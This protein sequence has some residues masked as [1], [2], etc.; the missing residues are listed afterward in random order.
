MRSYDGRI[1]KLD[2]H[3]YRLKESAKACGA[4]LSEAEILSFRKTIEKAIKKSR[5]KNAYIRLAVSL[6]LKERSLIIKELKRYPDEIF[7]KGA[8]LAT[9]CV[10][11]TSAA[12]LAVNIKSS[13]F[14]SA[15]LAKSESPAV[16]DALML[17]QDSYAA[18]GTVSNI[19]IVK[20]KI[21]FTPPASSGLLKGITRGVILDLAKENS[22]AASEVNLT[23][24][25]L[26]N[27]DECFLTNTTIE[28]LP[29]VEI[30]GR[31]IGSG[32]PGK[33]T[34]RLTKMFHIGCGTIGCHETHKIA[35]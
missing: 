2:E 17:Q 34:K 30:D 3:L 21:L 1:F 6:P 25:D 15:V 22:I 35:G 12:N 11:K 14:L 19:F 7:Q 4:E 8:A 24:H 9:S 28:I 20:D 10:R 16:F 29:V 5:I 26:Y 23:R 31:K 18:E 27:S 32:K 33:L 13:N